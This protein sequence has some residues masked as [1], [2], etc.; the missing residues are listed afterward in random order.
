VRSQSARDSEVP[1]ELL[2]ATPRDVRPSVR[3]AAMMLGA[4]V[5]VIA[6]IWGSIVFARRAETAERHVQLFE[7]ERVLAAGDVI[8]LRKRGG[9]DDHR[10]TVHYRYTAGGR[11]L[12]GATALRRSERDTYAVGSPVG[13][14]YLRSDPGASWLDGY[15]P[16]REPDW[17]ATVVPL[18]AGAAALALILSV[19]RQWNLLM[20]GRPAI[21][22][23]TRVEKKRTHEGTFWRV[24]YEWTLMTGATRTGRSTHHRK[25]PPAVGEH[26][27][28]VHDR[29]NTH[30]SSEYPMPFVSVRRR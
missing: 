14:W 20:Y 17:L 1:R 11:E 12:T 30:R 15:A 28:I 5:L 3:G 16:R 4:A 22:T 23:V 18:A 27:T 25:H 19:R 24:H 8:H 26:I 9:G 2:K 10:V 6:G 21:A 13:V 7:S 29:D